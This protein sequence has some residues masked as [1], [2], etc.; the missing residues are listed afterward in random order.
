[1]ILTYISKRFLYDYIEYLISLNYH[2]TE[3]HVKTNSYIS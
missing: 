2:I 1:M 3:D